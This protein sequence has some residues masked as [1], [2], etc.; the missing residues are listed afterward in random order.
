MGQ[1]HS[2]PHRFLRKLPAITPL[3]QDADFLNTTRKSCLCFSRSW[4]KLGPTRS[5]AR[6][7]LAGRAIYKYAR[8]YWAIRFFHVDPNILYGG[9]LPTSARA[10]RWRV[11]T[12]C[13]GLNLE[14]L[15][16]RAGLLSWPANSQGRAPDR[17]VAYLLSS[18]HVLLKAKR[19]T[20]SAMALRTVVGHPSSGGFH[21]RRRHR[22]HCYDYLM[23]FSRYF[24]EHFCRSKSPSC[25]SASWW[26]RCAQHAW[27]RLRYSLQPALLGERPLVMGT[28]GQ[29]FSDYRAWLEAHGVDT[30]A[31]VEVRDEFTC[32]VL[33]QHR[34][35]RNNQIGR[36]HRRDGANGADLS[37]PT[38]RLG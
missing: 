37:F 34:P 30:S 1:K 36:S 2:I 19:S 12:W 27:L 38:S 23:T 15:W 29:D 16:V 5:L 9:K 31:V 3:I 20:P 8:M 24:K 35:P 21:E 14:R 33:C 18:S 6:E 26:I 28:G 25:Q 7:P 32:V 22:L 17:R 10:P 4:K 13:G 11:S